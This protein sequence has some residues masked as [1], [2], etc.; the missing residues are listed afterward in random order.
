MFFA[1]IERRTSERTRRRVDLTSLVT[2]RS[3]FLLP[4]SRWIFEYG[5][6][7]PELF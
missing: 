6:G 1:I 3:G 5:L 7:K 2:G 4:A